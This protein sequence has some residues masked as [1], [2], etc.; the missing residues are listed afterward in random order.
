MAAVKHKT[1]LKTGM[2]DHKTVR[3]GQRWCHPQSAKEKD[4]RK[5]LHGCWKLLKHKGHSGCMGL[6]GLC[7]SQLLHKWP[8]KSRD[9]SHTLAG[10]KRASIVLLLQG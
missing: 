8:N 7:G 6:N 3:L 5:A 2:S 1:A 10:E 4:T 9:F